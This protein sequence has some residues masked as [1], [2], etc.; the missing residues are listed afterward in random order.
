MKP[1]TSRICFTVKSVSGAITAEL[2]GLAEMVDGERIEGPKDFS[3][4]NAYALLDQHEFIKNLVFPGKRRPA[5][6][7]ESRR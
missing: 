4:K 1:S 2:L 3:G 7:L 6:T 5:Q